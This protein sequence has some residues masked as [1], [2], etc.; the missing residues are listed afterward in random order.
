MK[1]VIGKYEDI[2]EKIHALCSDSFFEFH[3]PCIEEYDRFYEIDRFLYESKH[4]N[5]FS[6]EYHGKVVIDLS[7]W[8]DC[9]VFNRYFE[10]FMYFLK[11]NTDKYEPF[12]ISER[13]CGKEFISR[14]KEYFDFETLYVS[15]P[16]QDKMQRTIGFVSQQNDKEGMQDVRS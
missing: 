6:N 4:L 13:Q 14:L 2:K 10:A 11:D 3:F 7:D 12:F 5:R 1:L 9:K 15:K 16:Q 8:S